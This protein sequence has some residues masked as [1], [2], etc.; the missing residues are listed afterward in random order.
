MKDITL[1]ILGAGDSTR[2]G[3]AQKK[4]WLRSGD[5]PFWLVLARRL[6]SYAD[7]E[8]III[9]GS[10]AEIK[11][12]KHF[13][14]EFCYAKGGATR[15]E[16]L[17]N[18]LALVDTPFVMSTD[19][20]RL[21]VSSE[22]VNRLIKSKEKADCIVP[23]LRCTDSIIFNG[24][25]ANRDELGLIGT[26]QLSQTKLLKSA[27]EKGEFYNDDS[28]AI[29]AVGG[30]IAFVEGDEN[31]FKLTYQK[32]LLKLKNLGF[33]PPASRVFS[34]HGFDVH[35]FKEGDFVTLC[36][37]KIAHDKGVLAHSDGD[38]PLHALCDA[39]FGAAALGDIG[40][41][42]PDN[43]PK[44]KGADSMQ[45]LRECVRVVKSYGFEIINA[46]ITILCEKPKITPHKEAMRK[47]VADALALAQNF[48]NIK[49]TTMEK[50]GFIGTGEGFG[51]IATASIRYFD[52]SKDEPKLY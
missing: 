48:V 33:A 49:A 37:V 26:P 23:I 32:D 2:F 3:L 29:A 24:S 1:I 21:G 39:L 9:V 16:S 11:H 51:A 20:A 13:A 46:D 50:M 52:W 25:H 36:G 10:E 47:N 17:K 7:F 12:M 18:A 45:L 8:K 43:D 31:A 40:E 15:Q 44:F 38:A 41:F 30:K 35:R 22:L 5:D 4:Q 14:P 27:L 28:A 42:F 19:A 6:A 34:G